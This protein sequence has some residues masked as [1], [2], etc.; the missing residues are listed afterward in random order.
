[1]SPSLLTE[2]NPDAPR[3]FAVGHDQSWSPPMS[4]CPRVSTLGGAAA[5]QGTRRKIEFSES[6]QVRFGSSHFGL[7][8]SGTEKRF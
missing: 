1:M 3:V 4:S 6:S 7:A 8:P 2:P 5:S